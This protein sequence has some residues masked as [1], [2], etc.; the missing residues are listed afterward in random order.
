MK[1]SKW[2]LEQD[3]PLDKY[4]VSIGARHARRLRREGDG[5]L[6]LGVRLA[7]EKLDENQEEIERRTGPKDRRKR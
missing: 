6:S 2:D 4:N 7:A 1:K 3:A 5:N